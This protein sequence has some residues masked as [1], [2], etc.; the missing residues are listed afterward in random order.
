M[1][2]NKEWRSRWFSS[3]KYSDF[4]KEDLAIRKLLNKQLRNMSVDKIEI[5]RS[6]DVLS[7]IVHTSRPG[8]I[9][10]RGGTGAEDLRAAVQKLVRRKTAVRL[11]IQEFKNPETSAAIV[12]ESMAEQVE[13]RIPYRRVIKQ[14]LAKIMANRS[15]KGAKVVVAGRLDGNEIARTEH[16]EQGSL[17][18]QTLRADID[19][20]R[21]TAYTTYGTV[22]IKVWIYKGLKF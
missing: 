2:V 1:T 4:L 8:L 11:D 5:E 7:V 19:Y 15:V 20:A 6:P 22:G 3:K 21:A 18:L 12:A 17:P 10:G 14:A 13:K 9:I 16:L